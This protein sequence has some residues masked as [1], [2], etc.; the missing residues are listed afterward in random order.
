M[1]ICSKRRVSGSFPRAKNSTHKCDIVA[2]EQQLLEVA[3]LFD[4][5]LCGNAA[6]GASSVFTQ[7]VNGNAQLVHVL[8]HQ[9]DV[10]V[11]T[12]E[13]RL[14]LLVGLLAGLGFARHALCSSAEMYYAAFAR[15]LVTM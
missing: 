7:G 4:S 6:A 5:A 10:R 2:V 12:R 9:V 13:R 15:T 3:A 11:H 1:E 14:E 8:E